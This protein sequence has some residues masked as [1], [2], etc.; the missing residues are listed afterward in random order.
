[1]IA[2]RTQGAARLGCQADFRY[3]A[4]L[5]VD[6]CAADPQIIPF[7][8]SLRRDEKVIVFN[9]RDA[10]GWR[11]E[12]RFAHDF[13]HALVSLSVSFDENG[14]QV[15][16]DGRRFGPYGPRVALD[17]TQERPIRRGFPGLSTITQIGFQGAVIEET[18]HIGYPGLFAAGG[19]GA[20]LQLGARLSAC[21]PAPREGHRE[22]PLLDIADGV[23]RVPLSPNPDDPAVLTA[24]IPGWIWRDGAQA[25]ALAVR[26]DTMDRPEQLSLTRAQAV[27]EIV[28]MASHGFIDLDDLS[29][30]QA[31][32]HAV[33]GRMVSDLPQ[34]TVAVLVKAAGR[35]GL[36]DF[37][38][39]AMPPGITVASEAP[40]VAADPVDR[41][42][43]DFIAASADLAQDNAATLRRLAS[44]LT[45]AER[46]RL[47]QVLVETL[48]DD[49]DPAPFAALLDVDDLL[50]AEGAWTNAVNAP[51]LYAMGA[52]DEVARAVSRVAQLPGEETSATA[53]GWVGR[54][55]AGPRAAIDG[56]LPTLAARDR[57]LGA[58]LSVLETRAADYW[59][60]TASTALTR[61][62]VDL[63]VA[64]DS[65]GS[66]KRSWLLHL[67]GR[68]YGLS[69][70]FWAMLD[71]VLP[72]GDAPEL[73]PL[74]RA[75]DA[76]HAAVVSGAN[77]DSL[78]PLLAP[79]VGVNIAGAD[80]FC[81]D[82]LG[83]LALNAPHGQP[84]R[85]AEALRW[86][87]HPLTPDD[88]RTPPR[89]R[90]ATRAARA[91]QH[92]LP[93]PLYDD[94]RR[95]VSG[96]CAAILASD[97]PDIAPLV[98]MLVPLCD[99]D[100]RWF[101]LGLGARTAAA[102][103]ARGHRQ[104]AQGLL[105]HLRVHVDTMVRGPAGVG[106]WPDWHSPHLHRAALA[107]RAVGMQAAVTQLGG[108]EGRDLVGMA[109][110]PAEP[111]HD[112]LICLYS[113][114]PNL[115]TRVAAIRQTWMQRAQAR[116]VP[117]LVFV[118]GGDGQRQG[119]VVYLDAPD[120]YESLPKKTLAMVDWVRRHTGHGALFKIDDDCHV[121]IDALL[122]GDAPFLHDYCG[123][124][125][126]R[127]RGHFNRVWHMEKS[128]G[129]HA[130]YTLDKSPEPSVYADGST[131]Y[132][133]SRHAMQVLAH[134]ASTPQG[135]ALIAQ[136]FMED[137]LV[138]D[139]LRGQGLALSS[140]GYQTSILRQ[141][142]ASGAPVPMWENGLSPY[143]GG[144]VIVTHLD[145][146]SEMA[147]THEQAQRPAPAA[148]KI[149]PS[150]HDAR[151][152]YL[153]NALDLVSPRDRLDRA[154]QAEVAVVA[155]LRNERA[156]IEPFLA[157]YRRMGVGAFLIADNLS[158]DGTGDLLAAQPDVALF[159]VDTDYRASHY[160]VDWQQALMANFRPGRWSLV[161]D[162]DEFLFW[163]LDRDAQ[164]PALLAGQAFVGADAARV[165]MLDMYP[166]GPLAQADM[167]AKGAVT[168]PFAVADHV[169]RVP[170]RQVSRAGGPF[171]NAPTFTSALRHRLIP[172]ARPDLFVVQKYA[173]LRYRPWMR[174][175]AG[176]HYVAECQPATRDLA[177]A[178]FK[179]HAGFHAKAR[180]ETRRGQHFN[181]A[182]E[183]RKY[184]ALLSEGR[185]EIFDP[186]VSVRWDQCDWVRALDAAR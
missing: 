106:H 55:L 86:V 68:L 36:A 12:V 137:K 161:A 15:E 50:M 71:P 40:T 118:G 159:S 112:L 35:L 77:A 146:P 184:L 52:F 48:G 185:N 3:G 89:V 133:L 105:A 30:L 131:G 83:P 7:H 88:A 147:R 162:A 39:E 123:R 49:G 155:S 148:T 31:I 143:R 186:D 172:G 150:H 175:T 22:M 78:A 171:A 141:V 160:G 97:S 75:F 42:H 129:P 47:V 124:R 127:G 144:S 176:L 170:F 180:A 95:R 92:A 156:L 128:R 59:A 99:P 90:H 126:Y 177:F 115:D 149:W 130:R 10:V 82:L 56:Q 58:F 33:H 110:N 152:G 87:V 66:E 169:D 119:D 67:A 116:G 25:V 73:D 63:I 76:L 24:L 182:E 108:P 102:L 14:A 120:D 139:L 5:N 96:A 153:S 70:S 74:R 72:Q 151:L 157:H 134:A 93:T 178:H 34:D 117:V 136:S 145:G 53:L 113:C 181:N 8:V 69:P 91:L 98:S 103:S 54:A 142:R 132:V 109:E 179:Y 44:D 62:M 19:G 43:A 85:D 51:L 13:A 65:L 138:G 100:Q 122:A 41:A 165:F 121:D 104:A 168:D 84:P 80:R 135:Q 16:V 163:S 18:I 60:P 45:R 4:V 125:L 167:T 173:L 61:A 107:L 46:C 166:K 79:F 6:F 158:D 27:D 114:R 29:A 111:G 28:R 26:T 140:E 17:L 94:L 1:M 38:A 32:E 57:M 164:L 81:A 37:I 2:F 174:L 183:Y 11:R 154:M 101:G 9:R 64:R 20:G 23:A 21:L